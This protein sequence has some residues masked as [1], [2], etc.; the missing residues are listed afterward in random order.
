MSQF[1]VGGS[2]GFRKVSTSSACDGGEVV[3]VVSSAMTCSS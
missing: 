3:V 2:G 1:L